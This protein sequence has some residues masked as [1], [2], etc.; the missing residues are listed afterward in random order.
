LDSV[1]RLVL[2]LVVAS[3]VLTLTLG[4]AS[5]AASVAFK[6]LSLGFERVTL[7][8]R[9]SVFVA[10]KQ[11]KLLSRRVVVFLC[12]LFAVAF[13]GFAS[14]LSNLLFVV[15]IEVFQHFDILH[16]LH[17]FKCSFGHGVKVLAIHFPLPT[18]G[19]SMQENVG[20]F[21]RAQRLS[22][23]EIGWQQR[24]FLM[25]DAIDMEKAILHLHIQCRSSFATQI[26]FDAF[27]DFVG[28][29]SSHQRVERFCHN[30][31]SLIGIGPALFLGPSAKS[32]N[33]VIDS[34]LIGSIISFKL[35]FFNLDVVLSS[36]FNCFVT[37][38]F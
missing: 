9:V 38:C 3:L 24:N 20:D 30:D 28:H 37:L 12:R 31:M 36:C 23:V 6:L 17:C 2:G 7:I 15:A 29:E 18:L 32:S 4:L 13:L 25:V 34:S 35:C 14:G 26:T 1:D 33:L 27:Q 8:H 5:V 21:I 11:A 16:K 22:H 19:R 10:M